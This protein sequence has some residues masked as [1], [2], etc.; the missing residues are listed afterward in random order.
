MIH[1]SHEAT[2]RNPFG[3]VKIGTEVALAFEVTASLSAEKVYLQIEQNSGI[4]AMEPSGVSEKDGF[5]R[6]EF[7]V[8]P[9]KAGPVFYY[10]S[11]EI[12]GQAYFYGNN[13][14]VTGGLGRVYDKNPPAFQITA[15]HDSP[16][17]PAWFK[18][19]VVY[20]IFPDRFYRPE[21]VKNPKK[22][23]FIYATWDDD[24]LY[25]KDAK[26]NIARW[27][28]FG[29][30]L[31]GIIAKLPYLKDM[32]ISCI[33]VNPIFSSP[34]NHRYDTSDYNTVDPMLGNEADFRRLCK[35]AGSMGIKIIL[36]GVFSHTGSDSIYFNKEGNYPGEGAYQS[37]D[38]KYHSWYRFLEFPDK[39]ESWWGIE[40]MPNV[41]ETDPSYMD[42]I[43]DGE[44]SVL[45]HWIRAGAA[46][47]RL[48]VADELPDKFIKKLR[49][50]LKG[51]DE[52]GVLI[53]EVWEDAS[54]KISYGER[55]TYLL[56]EGLDSVTNYP[57]RSIL[58]DFLT[59]MIGADMV[60]RRIMSLY[61]N[62]PRE[63][64]YSCLNLLGSHDVPRILTIMEKAHG[65]DCPKATAMLKLMVFLQM[66]LPGVPVIY[67]GDEAGLRGGNDPE[68]RKGYPWGKENQELMAW[69]KEMIRIRK[70]DDIFVSGDFISLDID[71]DV[72]GFVRS[73]EN[74]RAVVL[75]NRSNRQKEVRIPGF[76]MKISV[77]PFSY[78]IKK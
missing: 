68:N 10:F 53:G 3:A 35:T 36:D 48:D 33:Y 2:Y 55:R 43:I 49:K 45:A 26:G 42:F 57:L 77:Q 60:H 28:F 15:Y 71:E 7:T 75:V 78:V 6:Y 21:E 5:F 63:Q 70:S 25:L 11:F 12:K 54:N 39:Y 8:T 44:D 73:M 76:D 22:N 74:T 37:K 13:P 41:N 64:F 19:A 56:G 4:K 51:L 52:G 20:Q 50:R 18:N 27:D 40:N 38:S 66:T 46:G 16:T 59:G 32:G 29:G 65:R 47:W 23:T 34:S 58:I 17:V 30:N 24:P 14:E 1:N 67:Y 61:E 62:Y 31:E 72:Y 69:Y 9:D